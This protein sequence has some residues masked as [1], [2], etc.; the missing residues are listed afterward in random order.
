MRGAQAASPRASPAPLQRTSTIKQP[1]RSPCAAPAPP[2]ACLVAQE[3][4]D[5]AHSRLQGF[6]TGNHLAATRTQGLGHLQGRGEAVATAGERQ[7]RRRWWR[8]VPDKR[9]AGCTANF[10]LLPRDRRAASLGAVQPRC[11]CTRAAATL[12]RRRRQAVMVRRRA[13]PR[14][15]PRPTRLVGLVKLLV[16]VHGVVDHVGLFNQL[17]LGRLNVGCIVEPLAAQELQQRE[18][19]VAVQVLGHQGS[20]VIRRGRGSSLAGRHACAGASAGAASWCPASDAGARIERRAAHRL[21]SLGTGQ[22]AHH[23]PP[24]SCAAP[25]ATHC[26]FP[27]SHR[28]PRA[29]PSNHAG[30]RTPSCPGGLSHRRTVASACCCLRRSPACLQHPGGPRLVRSPAAVG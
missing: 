13:W 18:N 10:A 9:A 26:I 8:M 24:A 30:S 29:Q 17:Q 4:G 16:D 12:K 22:H 25:L 21:H 28:R 15:P 14:R 6:E 7:Q 1:L 19:Q 27:R 3:L 23:T 5:G 11:R 20:E 2:P